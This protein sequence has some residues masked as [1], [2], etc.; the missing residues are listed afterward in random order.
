MKILKN[1]YCSA[2]SSLSYNVL[3]KTASFST[4]FSMH[5]SQ[6]YLN[7]IFMH[8]LF[9]FCLFLLFLYCFYI[10]FN[11]MFSICSVLE[12]FFTISIE[13]NL[14]FTM[15]WY[16][17]VDGNGFDIHCLFSIALQSVKIPEFYLVDRYIACFPM[18]NFLV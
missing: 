2:W 14:N 12:E 6:T 16:T 15:I 7:R 11:L 10:R 13:V 3:T 17:T 8:M 18:A 4:G 9:F 5:K 1:Q